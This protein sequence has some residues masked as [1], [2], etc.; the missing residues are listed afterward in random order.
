[1]AD[2]NNSGEVTASLRPTP[3]LP[4]RLTD[5]S[6]VV[7]VGTGIWAVVFVVLLVICLAKGGPLGVWVW[8]AA[9]GVVLGFVGLGIIAWQRTA[10]RRGAKGAQ[11]GI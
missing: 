2:S 8:T 10:S 11:R 1:V 4:K 7:I 6:P 5:L 9:V 3:E